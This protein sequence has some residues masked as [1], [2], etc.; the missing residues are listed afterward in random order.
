MNYLF[1]TKKGVS[2]VV[3]AV[4]LHFTDRVSITLPL[5]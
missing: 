1:Y 5:I 3:L 2:L 4:N